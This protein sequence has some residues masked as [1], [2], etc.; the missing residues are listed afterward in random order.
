MTITMKLFLTGIKKSLYMFE[1]HGNIIMNDQASW[2]CVAIK[3][4]LKNKIHER[5]HKL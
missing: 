5:F 1:Y 4:L 2:G 3:K